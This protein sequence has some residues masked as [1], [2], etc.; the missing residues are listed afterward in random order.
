MMLILTS[1]Y[2]TAVFFARIVMPF[3]R[4]RSIESMT[5]SSTS[6][7]LRKA[8][9]CQ[10]MASTRVVLPW[11][12]CA[13]IATLRRSLR[14][15]IA[16]T[17]P[18]PCTWLEIQIFDLLLR[19]LLR[20]DELHTARQLHLLEQPDH[21]SGRVDLTP[22]DPVNGRGGERVV[23]VVPRLAERDDRQRPVVRGPV[24]A[25]ERALTEEVTDGVDAP[26]HV[27]ENEDAG[28]RPP[29]ERGDR[30]LQRPR[31]E[32]AEQRGERERQ[33]RQRPE[34]LMDA[35]DVFVCH[36]IGGPALVVG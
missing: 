9:D 19:E 7:F 29:Q 26:R 32:A 20:R 33:Q 35:H 27:V 25:A 23:T 36:E 8:P 4:S 30:S 2:R 12:T 10:S 15:D 14:L 13:T 18:D 11:S 28:E 17:F 6:W 22:S 24:V 1:P 21:R 34:A 31:D 5:P 3:S 16:P